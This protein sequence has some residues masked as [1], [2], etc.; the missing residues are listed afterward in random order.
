VRSSTSATAIEGHEPGRPVAKRAAQKPVSA[1]NDRVPA[2]VVSEPTKVDTDKT[3][4][5]HASSSE[6]S[7]VDEDED[8]EQQ[9]RDM[10]AHVHQRS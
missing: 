4:Q 10:L 1:A 8:D 9:W 2:K 3:G 6:E 5:T 7:E